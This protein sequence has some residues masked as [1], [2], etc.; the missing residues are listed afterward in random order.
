MQRQSN[1]LDTCEIEIKNIKKEVDI[2]LSMIEKYSQTLV[3]FEELLNKRLAETNE[4]IENSLKLLNDQK[5]NS[6]EIEEKKVPKIKGKN[7]W[8]PREAYVPSK[9]LPPLPAGSENFTTGR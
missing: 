2:K 4:K 3:K 1:F 6:K 9:S 8:I 5:D 7:L